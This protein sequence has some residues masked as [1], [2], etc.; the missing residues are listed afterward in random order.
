MYQL[1]QQTRRRY[2]NLLPAVYSKKDFCIYTTDSE[3]CITSAQLY[4]AGLYPPTDK[5]IWHDSLKWN[6]IPT[7]LAEVPILRVAPI[8][9][10]QSFA[11][12]FKIYSDELLEKARQDPLTDYIVLHSGI[13]LN[14]FS[15]LH[16]IYEALL[17][18]ESLG[19][20]LPEWTKK[21]Y[22]QMN[23]Y[24]EYKEILVKTDKMKKLCEYVQ[25][26]TN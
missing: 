19:L 16:F 14:D 8:Q 26:I 3:R 17:S 23:L 24:I 7:F 4:N 20:K 11:K 15:Q 22:P 9:Y 10:C 1:G 18:Q 5:E 12:D 2:S 21:V 13:E 6:P 25:T